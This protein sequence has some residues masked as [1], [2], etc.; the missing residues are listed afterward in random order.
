MGL[1]QVIVVRTDLG[2][3]KGKI[4]AQCAHASL[5]GF[6]ASGKKERE[7]WLERGSEKI[8][9]KASSEK[10]L[11]ELEKKARALK[12]PCALVRDAGF[13]Q[14]PAGSPTALAIGPAEEAKIDA[15]T[16]SLKL[17]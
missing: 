12:L 13:T 16:G 15:V 5:Q 10:E 14:I 4:A 3:G 6:L 11:R 8:V 2:M 7:A 9:V 1:K 17:L